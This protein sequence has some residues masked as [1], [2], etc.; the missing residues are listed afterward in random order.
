[1]LTRLTLYPL[2]KTGAR[3]F[4]DSTIGHAPDI[5]MSEAGTVREMTIM[6]AG[7]FTF[8][9]NC[10]PP[11][12]SYLYSLGLE[13]DCRNNAPFSPPYTC[14][15]YAP[16]DVSCTW[17]RDTA[18]SVDYAGWTEVVIPRGA[19]LLGNLPVGPCPANLY[20][21]IDC[22]R[23]L[24]FP[25]E[26]LPIIGGV[27]GRVFGFS[28]LVCSHGARCEDNRPYVCT[29]FPELGRISC[30]NNNEVML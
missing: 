26:D 1:M 29:G 13:S 19:W 28:S 18:T 7:V 14:E 25:G 22:T 17:V 16:E 20:S 27:N 9:P 12:G 4:S 21:S 30:P 23:E 8:R 11:I 15:I 10:A 3:W 6:G 2:C 5:G 24:A